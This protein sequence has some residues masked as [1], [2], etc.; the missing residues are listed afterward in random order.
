MNPSEYHQ[1]MV[2]LTAEERSKV[3]KAQCACDRMRSEIESTLN[4]RKA[5]GMK[6]GH[7]CSDFAN[8]SIPALKRVSRHLREIETALV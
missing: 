6:P 1:K 5:T 8:V 2:E 3:T 4:Y 7:D